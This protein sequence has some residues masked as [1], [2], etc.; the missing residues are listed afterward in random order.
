MFAQLNPHS[1]DFGDILCIIFPFLALAHHAIFSFE[2]GC[3]RCCPSLSR[4]RD[5]INLGLLRSLYKGGGVCVSMFS[6]FPPLFPTPKFPLPDFLSLSTLGGLL[7]LTTRSTFSF[8][9]Y[10]TRMLSYQAP[11]RPSIKDILLHPLVWAPT[12]MMKLFSVVGGLEVGSVKVTPII[13]ALC[14]LCANTSSVTVDEGSKVT[15]TGMEWCLQRICSSSKQT[16]AQQTLVWILW[17]ALQVMFGQAKTED[18]SA[19]AWATIGDL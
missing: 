18:C 9:M 2:P 1:S 17:S 8:L 4:H 15:Y 3:L 10:A 14:M 11:T 19:H 13:G 7:D 12:D 6:R 16:V 5:R